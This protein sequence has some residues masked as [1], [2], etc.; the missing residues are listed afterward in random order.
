MFHDPNECRKYGRKLDSTTKR[1]PVFRIAH[2]LSMY[3]V[4][5]V[6]RDAYTMRGWTYI[7]LS[8][9]LF[10]RKSEAAALLISDIDVPTNH[11]TGE[12]LLEDGLPRFLYVL[13][14]RSKTDQ[15]GQGMFYNHCVVSVTI[16]FM[17]LGQR[18]LLRRNV[19]NYKLCPVLTLM[20]WLAILRYIQG[21][22]FRI[23]FIT[24]I[25]IIL[26]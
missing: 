25:I 8:C 21:R 3:N 20:T 19:E 9:S 7:L 18:L 23:Q 1:A 11:V 26:D 5:Q 4:C 24:I 14:R 17:I 16:N 6:K 2:L 22:K 10:L 12:I 13:I 15:E